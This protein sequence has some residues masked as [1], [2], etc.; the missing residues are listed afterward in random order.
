MIERDDAFVDK[1]KRNLDAQAEALD[2]GVQSKLTRARYRALEQD[3]SSTK[4][5]LWNP[6]MGTGVAVA[7]ALILGIALS[8]KEM[9]DTNPVMEDLDLLVAEESLEFFENED[10]DFY[11]WVAEQESESDAG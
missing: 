10:I 6:L 2:A 11:A 3:K 7:L 4:V 9:P 1:I 8:L 5:G